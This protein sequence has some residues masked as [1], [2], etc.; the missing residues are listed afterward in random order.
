M[1]EGRIESSLH[2]TFFERVTHLFPNHHLHSR[3]ALPPLLCKVNFAARSSRFMSNLAR[4]RAPCSQVLRQSP[5]RQWLPRRFKI[6]PRSRSF[7]TSPSSSSRENSAVNALDVLAD[8]SLLKSTT[9]S[10]LRAHLEGSARTVYA[11]VDP[12]AA[13]LHLGNLL[14]LLALWHIRNAGHNI[15]V[16]VSRESVKGIL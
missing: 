9:S 3:Q 13:S 6:T 11:G 16:L 4:I 5:F 2:S 12:S 15:V 14:P 10:A 1:E 8:R 7:F